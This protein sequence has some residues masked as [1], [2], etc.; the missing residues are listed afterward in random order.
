MKR[1]DIT[2]Q[3]Y[4]KLTAK[5]LIGGRR[6]Y[7]LCD[8]E[9]GNK[10]EV[11][12]SSLRTGNTKSCGCI[13]KD[14]LINRNIAN[15]KHGMSHS[16]VERIHAG[17]IARCYKKTHKSYESYGGRG[18]S[19]CDEWRDAAT[20][21]GWALENGYEDGLQID[22]IDNDK[23]YDPSN[24]RWVSSKQQGNNRRNNVLIT[25]GGETRTLSEWGDILNIPKGSLT[26]RHK[27]G[28]LFAL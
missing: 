7:W 23:G 16:R 28:S 24:C 15:A 1:I 21:I 4:G 25:H 5:K 6:S 2:N 27:N 26:Y 20:F 22:R 8:C 19:V 18:I 12:L 9:C 10:I 17:M 14:Q 11:Q 3:R 13:H